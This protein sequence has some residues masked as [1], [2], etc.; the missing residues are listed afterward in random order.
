MSDNPFFTPRTTNPRLASRRPANRSG[1]S[2]RTAGSS[3]CE[4]RDDGAAG[5]ELQVSR[6][7]ELLYGRRWATRAL[8][9]EEADERKAQYLREGG[10]LIV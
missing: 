4:L 10:A 3:A 5:V 1:P 2:R 7:G 8:A 9:L 6:A